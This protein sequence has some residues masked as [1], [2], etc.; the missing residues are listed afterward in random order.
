MSSPFRAGTGS[1]A[2]RRRVRT[3]TFRFSTP[4]TCA[5]VRLRGPRA[6]WPKSERVRLMI[7]LHGALLAANSNERVEFRKIIIA[8]DATSTRAPRLAGTRPPHA[9]E[10]EQLHDIYGGILADG[11]DPRSA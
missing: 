9:G 7:A 3:V 10:M 4:A 11:S 2:A 5:V 6:A 1:H 8:R